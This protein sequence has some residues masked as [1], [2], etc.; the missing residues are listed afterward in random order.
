MS[1]AAGYYSGKGQR[2]ATETVREWISGYRI[3]PSEGDGDV[4]T[5][6]RQMKHG[7]L[8]SHYK[9]GYRHQTPT[10]ADADG[11]VLMTVGYLFPPGPQGPDRY[12]DLLSRCV[13]TRGKA[14]EDCEGEFVALFAEGPAGVVHL[15]SDR[16][17]ACPFYFLDAGGRTLFASNLPLLAFLAGGRLERDVVG[18]L[19]I[20]AWDH[21]VGSRTHLRDVRR[22]LPATHVTL[23]PDGAVH[24]QYWRLRAEVD[25][26][27]EPLETAHRV[28]D[29]LRH[30]TEQRARWLGKGMVA[31]SA[32]LDS[33]L[34]AG[35]LPSDAGF[36]AW[37]FVDEADVADS[38]NLRIAAEVSRILGLDHTI[39]TIPTGL[40]SPQLARDLIAL[41]GGMIS[42]HHGVKTLQ[43]IAVMKEAGIH[44]Q[45]GGAPGSSLS[46]GY[47]R[48]PEYT[49]PART[50]ECLRSFVHRKAG[51]AQAELL[52]RIFRRD[53]IQ[54]HYPTLTSTLTETIGFTEG[55]SAAHRV[56]QWVMAYRNFGFHFI[57]P[58]HSHPDV[59]EA[60]PHLGYSYADLLLRL[61]APWLYRKVFYQYMAYHCLPSLR[62]VIYGNT[63]KLL[64]GTLEMVVDDV[65]HLSPYRRLRRLAGRSLRAISPTW[66]R[67]RSF[68]A[69]ML[70]NTQLLTE[71]IDLLH[72][73]PALGAILDIERCTR[74][75]DDCRAGRVRGTSGDVAQLL[76]TVATMCYAGE[77]Y[78]RPR[79]AAPRMPE[80]AP[81]G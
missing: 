14:L 16:F 1:V 53:V 61:P 49:D 25:G 64:S 78:D 29:A 77:Y 33:R 54:E 30:A 72:S 27:A 79:E 7:H 26:G 31:L 56:S 40:V 13:R 5:D 46:G 24:R 69:D 34:V 19:E 59:S 66:R 71:T 23:S 76:G 10:V 42:F 74:F 15:V 4:L 60:Q 18:W 68:M 50:D 81:V 44:A 45:M 11:N 2:L 36:S 32:G 52:G 20:C 39:T 70:H 75:V 43:G 48:F 6:I 73:Q 57:C 8:I 51:P 63:G 35:T 22:L 37:T 21:A 17:G 80:A 38:P 41:N 58:I 47:V 3:L 55:P 67:R 65:Q 28:F 62:G 9:R 12:Q